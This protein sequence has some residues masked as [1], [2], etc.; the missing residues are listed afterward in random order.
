MSPS[1][2]DLA[3]RSPRVVNI[4]FF[5]FAGKVRACLLQ[6]ENRWARD[7]VDLVPVTFAPPDAMLAFW[8]VA[9]FSAGDRIPLESLSGAEITIMARSGSVIDR[10]LEVIERSGP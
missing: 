6:S 3:L 10:S 9:F 5:F 1:W 7:L 8:T 2:A 4:N